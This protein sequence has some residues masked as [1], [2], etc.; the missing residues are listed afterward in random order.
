MNHKY[1]CTF[2]NQD[3]PTHTHPCT[4]R[5]HDTSQTSL[6]TENSAT[7]RLEK[8]HHFKEIYIVS[9][10]QKKSN[11]YRRNEGSEEFQH[12]QIKKFYKGHQTDF[13]S[14]IHSIGQDE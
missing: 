13:H 1:K 12:N 11:V 8:V 3:T 14:I 7:H 9:K 2:T 4:F 6:Y 5:G 10:K